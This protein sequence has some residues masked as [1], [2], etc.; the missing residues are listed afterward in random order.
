MD[1]KIS[2]LKGFKLGEK[3]VGNFTLIMEIFL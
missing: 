3:F 1:I 2:K